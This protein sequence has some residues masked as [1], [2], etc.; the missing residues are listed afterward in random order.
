MYTSE[1]FKTMVCSISQ[2]VAHIYQHAI[3]AFRR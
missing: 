2:L 1:V 3:Y